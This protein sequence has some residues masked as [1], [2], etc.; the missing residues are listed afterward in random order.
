MANLIMSAAA[1][2]SM[3]SSSASTSCTYWDVF[4]NHRG[5][6]GKMAAR[7]LYRRL[8]SNGLRRVFFDKEEMEKAQNI[9]RQ[10][11][12]S[13]GGASLHISIFS[14]KYAESWWCLEELVL[15]LHS[16]K[17]I[18]PV[19][20]KVNNPSVVRH[21]VKYGEYANALRD[22]AKKTTADLKTSEENPRYSSDT[23]HQW[24]VALSTV[25]DLSSFEIG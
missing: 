9:S 7:Y 23:I 8:T 5:P 2:S 11:I 24:R 14:P 13:I 4:V 20:Y 22:L 19:F 1:S 21:N 15:M 6:D 3:A 12:D 18:L 17:P 16:G 10:I 25:A